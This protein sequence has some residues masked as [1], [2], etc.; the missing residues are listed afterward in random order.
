MKPICDIPLYRC[1]AKQFAQDL[2]DAVTAAKEDLRIR[3]LGVTE[4]QAPRVY[5][6]MER[7]ISDEYGEWSY[8]QVIGWLRLWV[9][10][11]QI[12]GQL[13]YVDKKRIDKVLR[14]KRFEGH[15]HVFVISVSPAET[16]SQVADRLFAALK[17]LSSDKRFTGRYLHLETLSNISPFLDWRQLVASQENADNGYPPREQSPSDVAGRRASAEFF[18]PFAK[19]K[20]EEESVYQSIKDFLGKELGAAFST[21]KVR[22]VRFVHDGNR[23]GAEVGRP[24]AVTGEPVIAI[25]YEPARH[26]YHVCTASRGVVRGMSILVGENEVRECHDFDTPGKRPP[27]TRKSTVRLR[28]P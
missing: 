9:A 26:L 20:E 19:D 10:A 13:F 14:K 18:I 7:H 27:P 21:R 12:G 5:G 1:S 15:G 16:S 23:C 24:Q 3:S 8:N 6:L 22:M 4:A 28:R 17:D 2:R 25:L 11:R